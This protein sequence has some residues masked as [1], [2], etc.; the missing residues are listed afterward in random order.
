MMN[1]T[2]GQKVKYF[3]LKNKLSQFELELDI[4]ASPGAICRLEG[5]RVNPT[6]ETLFS[7]AKALRLTESEIAYLFGII[8]LNQ[9]IEQETALKLH[10]L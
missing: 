2:I 6:K 3:R 9:E 8:D 7:I 5:N 1:L 4:N 10:N